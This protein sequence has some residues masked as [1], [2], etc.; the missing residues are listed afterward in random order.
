MDNPQWAQLAME[1]FFRLAGETTGLIASSG[2]AN[3]RVNDLLWRR[4]E[5]EQR[6]VELDEFIDATYGKNENVI[7]QREEAE[8]ELQRIAAVLPSALASRDVIRQKILA[9]GSVS[10]AAGSLLV[11]LGI[12]N[13][14]EVAR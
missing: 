11:K 8:R 14:G 7:R 4:R 9:A 10:F 12:L 13:P 5:A 3:D 2:G 6:I 1:K